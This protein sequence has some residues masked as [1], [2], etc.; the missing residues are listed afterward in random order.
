MSNTW[1]DGVRR[2]LDQ[3]EHE[4][5]NAS[6]YPGTREMCVRCDEPTGASEEH[7]LTAFVG[8]EPNDE[9][10]P[11]CSECYDKLEAIHGDKDYW[12]ELG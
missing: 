11:V 6:N 2:A 12:E 5:W 9:I 4:R 10:T 7:S 8:H 1:P 3:D